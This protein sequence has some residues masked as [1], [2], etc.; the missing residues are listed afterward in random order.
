M[1]NVPSKPGHGG[2]TRAAPAPVLEDPPT[3]RIA[4]SRTARHTVRRLGTLALVLGSAG[5]AACASTRANTTAYRQLPPKASPDLV[6]VY[7]DGRPGRPYQELGVIEVTPFG[8]GGGEGYGRLIQ[9]ARIEA[10]KMGADAILV[11]RERRQTTNTS[12]VINAPQRN[13]STTVQSSTSTMD[14]PRLAVT[15]IVWK[16]AG[17]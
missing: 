4:R 2:A 12:G 5:A 17:Q 1:P 3:M 15:A 14:E 9:R 6:E 16:P 7:A 11:T 8:I 13:G 10:A